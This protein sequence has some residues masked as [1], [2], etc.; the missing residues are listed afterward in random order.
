MKDALIKA[1]NEEKKMTKPKKIKQPTKKE[2]ADLWYKVDSEGFGYYMLDYG[3][4]WDL[5]G[6]IGFD[7]EK[8]KSACALLEELQ[9]KIDSFEEFVSE[10]NDD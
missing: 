1:L 9:A 10:K 2:L 6:R 4:D 5:I 8:V 3:P 7:V